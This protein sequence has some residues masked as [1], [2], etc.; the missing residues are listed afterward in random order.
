MRETV[1][2]VAKIANSVTDHKYPP[3]RARTGV[4]DKENTVNESAKPTITKSHSLLV[5][6]HSVLTNPEELK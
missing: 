5:K 3:L 1:K 6:N 2:L 4:F